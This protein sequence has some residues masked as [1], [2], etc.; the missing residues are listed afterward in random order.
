MFMLPPWTLGSTD[1]QSHAL[2]I[3]TGGNAFMDVAWV[4]VWQN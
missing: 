1:L 4:R 3:D 2:I